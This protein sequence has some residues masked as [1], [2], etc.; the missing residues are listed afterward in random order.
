[1]NTIKN[2]LD[3]FGAAVAHRLYGL[4]GKTI[5]VTGASKGIGHTV[6]RSC[7]E[8]GARLVI[9]GRD[10]DYRNYFSSATLRKN[11][12]HRACR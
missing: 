1:M 2:N 10:P 7:A 3:G 11:Q 12:I 4:E 5:L 8:A 9:S 6:A